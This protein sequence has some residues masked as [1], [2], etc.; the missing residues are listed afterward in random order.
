[1]AVTSTFVAT[2][3]EAVFAILSDPAAFGAF[4]VGT[5]HIR[6]FEPTWPAPGSVFHHTLGI[7]PFILRDL[8]R[9][10]EVEED[11]RLVLRAQMRPL[12]VNR[13]DFNL[14]PAHDGTE[15]EVEEYAI[16]GPV[17]RMWNAAFESAMHLRNEEMLRR[18]K[19]IVERR[20]ARRAELPAR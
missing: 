8:T 5:K 13:V 18:L 17:A 19:R 4:V 16:E 2:A 20:Q 10:E 7:G 14:R 3:P 11:R 12:A 6:S 9:V 15:V 1:M